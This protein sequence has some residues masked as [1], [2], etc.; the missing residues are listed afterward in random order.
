MPKSVVVAVMDRAVM[1][2]GRPVFYPSLGM[3]VRQFSDEVKRPGSAEAPNP[4]NQ[5]PADFEMSYLADF[6]DETGAFSAP[7]DGP[8]V[9]LR[10][11]EVGTSEG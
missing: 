11:V 7:V 6:D 2:Y 10:A 8:R 1:A 3:A 9:V 4:M 5:H